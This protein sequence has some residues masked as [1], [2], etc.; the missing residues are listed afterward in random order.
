MLGGHP[1]IALC[2]N[3]LI[4]TFIMRDYSYCR[5]TCVSC[6]I[7]FTVVFYS[8]LFSELHTNLASLRRGDTDPFTPPDAAFVRDSKMRRSKA[9]KELLKKNSHLSPMQV[10]YLTYSSYFLNLKYFASHMFFMGRKSSSKSFL[11][12]ATF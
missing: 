9:A 2:K 7:H 8:T 1:C 4:S 10:S 12:L 11:I 5:L 3:R 6:I